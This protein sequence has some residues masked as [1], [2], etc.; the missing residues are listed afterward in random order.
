[1]DVPL[2]IVYLVIL[3]IKCIIN[4]KVCPFYFSEENV[5]SN[6]FENNFKN[7]SLFIVHNLKD[8][9]AIKIKLQENNCDI[10][11]GP[12]NKEL[13]SIVDHTLTYNG[14]YI[15]PFRLNRKES[16][17]IEVYNKTFSSFNV[18]NIF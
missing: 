8:L 3:L 6:I 2:I 5:I 14:T 17:I 18:I 16:S 15:V 9:R 10:I 11:I 12:Q 7:N 13:F 4:I 1:M